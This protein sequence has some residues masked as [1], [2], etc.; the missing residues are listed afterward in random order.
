[1]TTS[2]TTSHE[3]ASGT[4]SHRYEKQPLRKPLRQSLRPAPYVPQDED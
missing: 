1:M 2:A 4:S 3:A